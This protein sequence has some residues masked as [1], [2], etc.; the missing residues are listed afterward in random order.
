[1]VMTAVSDANGTKLPRTGYFWGVHPPRYVSSAVHGEFHGIAEDSETPVGSLFEMQQSQTPSSLIPPYADQLLAFQWK[2]SEIPALHKT[3]AAA[4][5]FPTRAGS[6][7]SSW[8]EFRRAFEPLRLAA[9]AVIEAID[10]TLRRELG[11]SSQEKHA[12]LSAVARLVDVLGLRRPVILRMAGVPESTFYAWRKNPDSVIRT[13]T[14]SRLLRLQAQVAILDE[15]LG[16]ERMRS[17]LLSADRFE[18]LQG[19]DTE[20]AQVLDEAEAD[21]RD[22]AR[23]IPRRRMRRADYSASFAGETEV[24]APETAV[25][26]GAGKVRSQEDHPE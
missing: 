21:V 8:W 24:S 2:S 15:A 7:D 5:F 16:R 19:N 4:V 17:W 12:G 23:I 14:I 6:T 25:W 11:T 13:S 3:A 10:D 20:F 1:M 9:D 26:P 22:T 18:R